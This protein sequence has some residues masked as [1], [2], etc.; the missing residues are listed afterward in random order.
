VNGVFG[1]MKFRNRVIFLILI[2]IM[3]LAL[4]LSFLTALLLIFANNPQGETISSLSWAGYII[5]RDTNA[6]IQVTAMNASWTI[7]TVVTSASDEHSSV[8]IGVGGQLDNT[9]IQ[10][11]TEQDVSGGQET[12]Y[13]WYELLPAYAVRINTL[14][15]SPGDIMVASL[16]LVDS[17]VNRWN[18]QIS[19]STTGQY[20]G[21][22]VFYNSTR[23]SGEWVIERPTVSTKLSAL[24][25]FGN[26]TFTSCHLATE[27]KSGPIKSFYFS[28][29]EMTNSVNTQLT[30]V[31]TITADGEGFT[32]SYIQAQ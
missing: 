30:S 28:R 21:T 27:N 12:Y 5:S 11:G 19:D 24:A 1:K 18:I 17:S 20:F 22:T 13:A 8:W 29:I 4:V 10:A 31:S 25:D 6:K 2:W 16:R 14:A 26:V 7:P 9:L 3:L 15:V 32:T 23:S